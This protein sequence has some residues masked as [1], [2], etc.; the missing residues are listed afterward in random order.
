MMAAPNASAQITEVPE[1]SLIRVSSS[2][3][4]LPRT[5]FVTPLCRKYIRGHEV[6]K[7]SPLERHLYRARSSLGPQAARLQTSRV[8]VLK[9]FAGEPPAV[10]VKNAPDMPSLRLWTLHRTLCRMPFEVFLQKRARSSVLSACRWADSSVGR[11]T[12]F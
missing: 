4:Q 2:Y 12:G 11:A 7:H 6:A 10:P 3:S 1:R 9:D 8:M 5:I